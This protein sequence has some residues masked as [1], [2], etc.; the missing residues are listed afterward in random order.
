VKTTPQKGR[1]IK[2]PVTELEFEEGG[3]AIWIHGVGFTAMRIKVD[4]VTARKCNDSPRSHCDLVLEGEAVVC[5][6]A[7]AEV[8]GA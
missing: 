7:D 6:G 4:K 5:L 3:R 8:E 1:R 2:I